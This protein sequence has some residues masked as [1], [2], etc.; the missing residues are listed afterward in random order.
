LS[1]ALQKSAAGTNMPSGY[2]KWGTKWAD[3]ALVVDTGE[4]LSCHK[5]VLAQ[6]SPFF[7]AMLSSDYE[8]TKSNKMKV[9]DFSLVTV[10]TF[11]EYL[12]IGQVNKGLDKAKITPE[13]MRLS[14][15]YDVQCLYDM[16]TNHLKEN[17]SDTNA[18]KL[19]FEAE[20]IDNEDLKNSAVEYIANQKE[21][22]AS[23][24]DVDAAYECP[25]LMKSIFACMAKGK[26]VT[27]QVEYEN[28]HYAVPININDSVESFI[29]VAFREVQKEWAVSEE[30][31]QKWLLCGRMHC[32]DIGLLDDDRTLKSYG[33]VD[34]EYD[35]R[36][37]EDFSLLYFQP[38]KR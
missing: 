38:P 19:W 6:N 2:E 14:H 1:T 23:W 15:M 37:T 5:L 28:H 32:K 22:I 17:I 25:E 7:E 8:E 3:F 29:E 36:L 20:K 26:V 12:Y 33:F 18:V 11:L 31:V 16:T 9:K 4:E 21:D 10:T 24:A 13:L 34:G 30:Q 27:V 35:R